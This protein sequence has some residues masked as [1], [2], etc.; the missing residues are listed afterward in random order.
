MS[1]VTSQGLPPSMCIEVRD[2]LVQRV[3]GNFDRLSMLQHLGV[4]TSPVQAR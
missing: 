4:V 2:G 3:E 1:P